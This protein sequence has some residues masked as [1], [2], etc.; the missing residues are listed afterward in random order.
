MVI[1]ANRRN[2][3]LRPRMSLPRSNIHI[4][5]T[6]INSDSFLLSQKSPVIIIIIISLACRTLAVILNTH[7]DILTALATDTLSIRKHAPLAR[8]Y[9]R[10]EFGWVCGQDG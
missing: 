9:T 6:F 1:F 3:V 8:A 7:I 4:V 2:D 5:S 10:F